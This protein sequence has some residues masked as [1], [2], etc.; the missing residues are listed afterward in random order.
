MHDDEVLRRAVEH[1]FVPGTCQRALAVLAEYGAQPHEREHARVRFDLV[2][3]CRG[4][5]ALLERWLVRA[6]RD[7]RD[8]L[9]WAEDRRDPIT[10]EIPRVRLLAALGLA[11]GHP[12][13][14][15]VE[16]GH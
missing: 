11:E 6:Q 1:Y 8:V 12:G 9:T 2:A 13:A 16:L 10:G 3:L 7:H 5:L 14:S 15:T 4:D